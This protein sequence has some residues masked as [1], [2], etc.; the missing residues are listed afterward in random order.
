MDVYSQR[1][2][3]KA[4]KIGY[5]PQCKNLWAPG[6]RR[7]SEFNHEL[8]KKSTTCLDCTM[9]EWKTI[10]PDIIINHLTGKIT[11][12][13]YPLLSDDT[14]R[15]LVFD[16]DNHSIKSEQ[17]D[18]SNEDEKWKEEVSALREICK[19]N[20]IDALVERSRSGNGAHVWIFFEQPI[21][22]EK[23]RKFGNALLEKGAESVNLQNFRYYDRMIPVQN[24]LKNGGLGNLIAL[25]LQPEA[26][27]DGN[28]AFV[29]DNW[30][31]YLNQYEILFHKHRLTEHEIDQRIME[32]FGINP[33]EN[34]EIV[35]N[36]R[37]KPW[38][39]QLELRKEDVSGV[40]KI[41]VSNQLFIDTLNLSPRI[42]NQIRKMAAFRNP[43]FY[44]NQA[45]NISN[46]ANS[47]FIYLGEDIDGY[48][49]IPRGILSSLLE[50]LKEAEILYEIE[51]KRQN[52]HKIHV[53]FHGTLR[54]NQ[55]SA[56]EHLIK[57]DNGILSAATAFGKTV[58][59]CN[60]I[61]CKKVNTLILLES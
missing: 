9:Q 26:L 48:I 2:V 6:C 22:A 61:A 46:F 10:T 21:K 35:K 7:R 11:I 14:C 43:I 59:C 12:G 13:I 34:K 37:N 33:F 50:R 49:A 19:I 38:E 40:F 56:V 27:K 30:N 45:M 60:L 8:K 47:R 57:Y 53:D 17:T 24:Y 3:N 31:A 36:T 55:R 32:W 1:V 15:F 4:G 25:P 42:Q 58:V 16:F 20:N 51:D 41:V 39:N 52:G 28:S 18:F 5:Y 23:A 44:K 54:D 29:D